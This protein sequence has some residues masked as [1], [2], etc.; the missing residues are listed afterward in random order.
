MKK[1]ILLLTSIV[2]SFT[3]A[4]AQEVAKDGEHKHSKHHVHR[5]NHRAE[6][7]TKKLGL[8]EEQKTKIHTISLEGA[9]KVAE[10]K[11]QYANDPKALSKVV[12]TVRADFRKQMKTILTPEQFAKWEKLKKEGKKKVDN[13]SP[14]TDELDD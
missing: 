6:H 1:I 3:A 12:K 2:L 10:A 4:F 11:K 7:L 9:T 14:D 5:A 13:E 8:T